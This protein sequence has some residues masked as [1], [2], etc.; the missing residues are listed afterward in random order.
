MIYIY[1]CTLGG[2][3]KTTRVLFPSFYRGHF[4]Q[5]S[6]NSSR[7]L[8]LLDD[9]KHVWVVFSYHQGHIRTHVRMCV[10]WGGARHTINNAPE[11]AAP[12]HAHANTHADADAAPFRAMLEPVLMIRGCVIW[13]REPWFQGWDSCYIAEQSARTFERSNFRLGFPIVSDGNPSDQYFETD[14]SQIEIARA[15]WTPPTCSATG[16]SMMPPSGPKAI[17]APSR[18]THGPLARR[19]S[20]AAESRVEKLGVLLPLSG[21]GGTP[22]SE[23]RIGSGRTPRFPDSCFTTWTQQRLRPFFCLRR[24]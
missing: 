2:A 21:G 11:P 18:R 4:S 14:I 8:T 16:M 19:E 7:L 9:R 12:L 13:T 20:E 24:F 17:L 15:G 3:R 10:V 6:M 5:L 1:S 23:I 22:P